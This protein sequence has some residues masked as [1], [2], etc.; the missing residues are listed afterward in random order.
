[1]FFFG[2]RSCMK[3]NNITQDT[4]NYPSDDEDIVVGCPAQGYG[5]IAAANLPDEQWLYICIFFFFQLSSSN[6]AL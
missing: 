3:K 4:P 6:M 5:D 1:M 2:Y